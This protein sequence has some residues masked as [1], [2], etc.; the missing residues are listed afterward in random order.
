M[1]DRLG[2]EAGAMDRAHSGKQNGF[3]KKGKY[4][5]PESTANAFFKALKIKVDLKLQD[6]CPWTSS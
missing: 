1:K 3:K 4:E 2:N 5:K 6:G